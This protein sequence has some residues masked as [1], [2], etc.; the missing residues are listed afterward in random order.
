MVILSSILVFLL[1]VAVWLHAFHLPWSVKASRWFRLVIVI[2]Y[3]LFLYGLGGFLGSALVAIGTIRLPNDLE[4]PFVFAQGYVTTPDGIH[5][6]PNTPT[7]R[8]QLY[9]ANWHFIRGWN[10]DAAG[11]TFLLLPAEGE[12]VEIITERPVKQGW[13]YVCDLHGKVL[14]KDSLAPKR[15]YS[16]FTESEKSH[17]IP[18]YPW[19]WPLAHP[20]GTWALFAIGLMIVSIS[21]KIINPQYGTYTFADWLRST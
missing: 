1:A 4:W 3:F 18:T 19:L 7:G 8:I 12:Q 6:A 20:V 13:H 17:S 10:I 11:G 9:D 2:G 21:R 14:S 5:I 15:K 16:D